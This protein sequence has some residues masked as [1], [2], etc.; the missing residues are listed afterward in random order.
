MHNHVIHVP[1]AAPHL[2]IDVGCGTGAVS[3]YLGSIYPEAQIYGI[4]L[5]PVPS[6]SKPPNVHYIQG[7]VRSLLTHDERLSPSTASFI[8]SRLLILG[9]ADW[10]GYIRDMTSLLQSGG[11][12]EMQE[13]VFELYR[14]GKCC[15]AEWG[16]LR[17]L[18]EAAEKRGWDLRCGGRGEEYMKQ[19][20]LVDVQAI[21]YRIPMGTWAV[22]AR[23]ETRR[24]GGHA[25]REYGPLYHQ[26]LPKLLDGMGYS[27]AEIEKFREECVRD[28]REEEGKEVG[29]W[30]VTGRK[31]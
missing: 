16:W 24:I 11:W 5:T 20:G 31:V 13:F 2:I 17:A 3:R 1:L 7:E 27:E 18:H 25:A 10:P 14:H 9:M 29:F 21:E 30:V 4:D 22:E 15:S 28:L 19:A 23:P 8:F 26:A 6:Q 12:I